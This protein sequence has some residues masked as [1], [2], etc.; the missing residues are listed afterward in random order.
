MMHEMNRGY[1]KSGVKNYAD[2]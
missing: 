2:S 1:K